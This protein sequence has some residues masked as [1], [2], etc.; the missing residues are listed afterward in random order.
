M[1][2]Y[3]IGVYN[4]LFDR[5]AAHGY[6]FNVLCNKINV[7]KYVPVRFPYKEISFNSRK[8][9]S[10]IDQMNP[11]VVIIFLHL[12]DSVQIP[13]VLHCNRNKIP[14]VYW[15]KGLCD[16]G[17]EFSKANPVWKRALYHWIH[18]RCDACITYTQAC[19]SNYK[20]SVWQRLFVAPN[21]VSFACVDKSKYNKA[22]VK[23]KYQIPADNKIVLFSGTVDKAFKRPE[24][25]LDALDGI[26]GVSLVFMGSCKDEV[27]LQQIQEQS[28]AYYVGSLYGDDG[29]ELWSAADIISIPGNLGLAA[30]EAMFWGCPVAIV[31]GVHPPEAY[32]VR[33][34]YNGIIAKNDEDFKKRLAGLLKD[35]KKLNQMSENCLATYKNEISMDKMSQGFLDACDYAM[36]HVGVHSI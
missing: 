1:F 6:E 14:V 4:D 17:R 31:K 22:F 13:V 33:D 35:D 19:K 11:S 25:L 15:N 28:N 23:A 30:N 24:L 10:I 34:G 27:L 9:K 36:K 8:Y 12:K 3:R 7:V 5:F 29:Y 20:E 21:T 2:P 16:N 18:G 32:C 26:D